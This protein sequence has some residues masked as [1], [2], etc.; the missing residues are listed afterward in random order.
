MLCCFI[1]MLRIVYANSSIFYLQLSVVMP[2]AVIL[3]VVAPMD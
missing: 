3:N 2:S 1:V